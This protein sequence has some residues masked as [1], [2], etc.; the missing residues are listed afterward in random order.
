MD[1][2]DATAFIS[3]R[4]QPDIDPVITAE[5]L[6][7]LLDVAATVDH[8]GFLPSEEDW[9][10]TY[11]VTGC[12]RAIVEGYELKLAKSLGRYDFSTDGQSFRRSQLLDHLEAQRVR[13]ARRLNVSVST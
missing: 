11:D 2:A 8:E 4:L 6:A 10:P 13:H 12:Y 3:L 9:T 7:Q 1:E 5:E